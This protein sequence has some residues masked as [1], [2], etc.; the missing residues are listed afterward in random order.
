MYV[1]YTAVLRAVLPCSHEKITIFRD[2]LGFILRTPLAIRIGVI[3]YSLY[4]IHWPLLVFYQ[5]AV[6]RDIELSER[7]V[8]LLVSFILATASYRW[9]EVPFRRAVWRTAS[10]SPRTYVF[11]CIALAS[12]LAIPAL[13]A[14]QT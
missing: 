12:A 14:W 13:H 2:A 10:P 9:I 3:S 6:F 11:R 1:I 4:L 8:L 7:I 5:R